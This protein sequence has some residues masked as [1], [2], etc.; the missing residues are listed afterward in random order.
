MSMTGK[1][2]EDTFGR[3]LRLVLAFEGG[4]SDDPRDPGGATKYGISQRSYPD[5][6]VASLS[7]EQATAIYRRDYWDALDLGRLPCVL[8]LPVFDAAV[9]AGPRAGVR[10]LQEALNETLADEGCA[11]LATDGLLGPK[12]L[13]RVE[14][15]AKAGPVVL[16][17]VRAR[18]L[19]FRLRFYLKLSERPALRAFLRGWMRRVLALEEEI[20]KNQP[21]R[22]A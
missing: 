12:T 11:V 22:T 14:Q 8:A 1:E 3:A 10:W 7:L 5:L 13:A 16:G 19:L 9:N 4:W 17:L 6:D 15:V 21:R 20:E 2:A 18:M